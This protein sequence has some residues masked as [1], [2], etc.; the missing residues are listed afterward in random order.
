SDISA[1]DSIIKINKTDLYIGEETNITFIAKDSNG[2]AIQEGGMTVTFTLLGDGTSSGVF[3]ATSDSNGVYKSTLTATNFGSENTIV[4]TADGLP[5]IQ[6]PPLRLRVISGDYYREVDLSSATDQDEFQVEVN[7]ST[8]NFDYSKVQ[9]NGDDIRFFDELYNEQDYWIENWNPSG[10]SKIWVKVQDSGTDKLILSYG[11]DSI[12]SASSVEGVFSYD[13]NKDIYYELSQAAGP[14]NYGVTSYIDNN[15]VNILTNSGYTAENI[16]T[17]VATT[18]NNVING[19]VSVDGPISAR[20]TTY[21]DGADSI[22][23][24][25][26]ASTILSY[27]KSRGTDDWDLYNPNSSTANLTLYNYNGSGALVDSG[28]YSIPPNSSL[29]ID[30]DVSIMG[31]IESDIPIL[32]L[33]YYANASDGVIMMKPAQSL[34]GTAAKGGSVGIIEDGTSGLIYFSD[35]S[36]ELFSGDRG[37]TVEFTGGGNQELALGIKVIADKPVTAVSQ[38]DSDGS[39]STSFWPEGELANDYII[40]GNSQYII[41]VCSEVVNLT[42]TDPGGNDDSAVCTPGDGNNPGVIPF[43]SP[44]AISY[45]SGTRVTGDSNF[46]MYYEHDVEDETNVLSWK[47]AR[48]YSPTTIF[49]TVGSEQD[50]D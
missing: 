27:P 43:G 41:V 6:L 47:Q 7:L 30:Y 19:L 34:L 16:S 21:D 15:N 12:S 18:V 13:T 40:P 4:V 11:N 23:P 37:D 39:D 14:S 17:G 22:A 32:G 24:L 25:S 38:A 29:H 1:V 10:N 28:G 31:L 46:Y 42:L 3:S 20:Y 5:I 36:T 44:T 8:S 2:V 48:S 26:F 35:G 9:N 49:T 33:Y 50:I 45:L